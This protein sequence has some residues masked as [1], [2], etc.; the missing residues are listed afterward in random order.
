MVASDLGEK[1]EAVRTIVE[2]VDSFMM[3]LLYHI[4]MPASRKNL[5]IFICQ[6]GRRG[7]RRNGSKPKPAPYE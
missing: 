6:N 7:P 5:K 1:D 2:G 3:L 4:I